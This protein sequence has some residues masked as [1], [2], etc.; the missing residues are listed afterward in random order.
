MLV[1][2]TDLTELNV[3]K[4]ALGQPA[5]IR[6]DAIPGLDII[7][8][9][10]KIKPFGENRQGDVVYTVVLQLEQADPRLKWNMTASVTFLDENSL[11]E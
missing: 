4:I 9:V 6:F 3:D 5:M 10:T 1:E 8:R 11:E 2:T 7:G